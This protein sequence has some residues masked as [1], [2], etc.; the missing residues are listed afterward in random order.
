MRSQPSA[1]RSIKS[2]FTPTSGQAILAGWCALL[3]V[4]LTI[5][6]FDSSRTAFKQASVLGEAEAPASSVIFTQRES[7]VFATRIGEWIGGAIPRR[8]VQ[9]SRAL[10]AQ[11]LN[12]VDYSGSSTGKRA[13][14][15]YISSLKSLDQIV[16]NAPSGLLGETSQHKVF[17]AV[18]PFLDE[19]ILDARDL[20]VQYQQAIDIQLNQVTKNRAPKFPTSP[21][22]LL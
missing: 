17:L 3:L 9:I 8:E 2:G 22:R 20:V 6:T 7:L 16:D 1:P 10:L 5:S 14:P 13:K 21:A 4:A 15:T 12:V 19:F 11:R 18:R